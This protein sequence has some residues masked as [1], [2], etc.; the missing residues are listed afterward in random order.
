MIWRLVK[1]DS[2]VQMVPLLTAIFAVAASVMPH[3]SS[4]LWLFMS[5]IWLPAHAAQPQRR[6]AAHHS[7]LPILARDLFLARLLAMFGAMVMP[8][9]AAATAFVLRGRTKDLDQL[10]VVA[11]MASLGILLTHSTRVREI[12]SSAAAAPLAMLASI[13]LILPAVY[14]LETGTILLLFGILSAGLFWNIWRQLPLAFEVLP[15]QQAGGSGEVASYGA[16]PAPAHARGSALLAWMPLL[17]WVGLRSLMFLPMIIMQAFFG[18]WIFVS[19]FCI[20][21]VAGALQSSWPL[22]LPIRRGTLLAVAASPWLLVLLTSLAVFPG[23]DRTRIELTWSSSN[24]VSSMRLPLEY[25][26]FGSSQ[27]I[28]APWGERTKPDTHYILGLP[29]YDPYQFGAQNSPQFMEWQFRHA[30]Q[31]IYGQ[32]ISY[33]DYRHL[34][35]AP[36]IIQR[37]G[38][39]VMNIAACGCWVAFLLNVLLAGFHWRLLRH[40]G[41]APYLTNVVFLVPLALFL[42]AAFSPSPWT[43]NSVGALV[44]MLLLHLASRLPGDGWGV[45]PLALIPFAILCWTAVRLMGGMEPPTR[46]A[47]R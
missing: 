7:A 32:P 41:Q 24:Q 46:S 17:R 43:P 5:V 2:A 31:A 22:A 9:A 45:L 40:T 47:A 14:F 34:R 3:S 33:E 1:A 6:A 27:E 30:T 12:S 16:T 39:R 36:P 28:V 42:Y 21:P 25:W 35:S 29:L 4:G 11:A 13:A 44:N 15:Y 37:P 23:R 8:L 26:R 20:F 38:L 18:D 10:A 19:L